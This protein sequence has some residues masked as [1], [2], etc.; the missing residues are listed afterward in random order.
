M[1]LR[2]GT[3]ASALARAQAGTVAADLHQHGHDVELVAMR[4]AGDRGAPAEDK[5]RWVTDLDQALLAGELDAAV[6]SAKDVPTALAEGLAIVC[7]PR[8]AD[9]RDAL[10]GVGDLESLSRGARVGTGSLRRAA[11]LLALR[12]D[13]ELVAVPG[14]VDTRLKRL[15]EGACDALVLALAGLVRLGREREAGG[16]IEPSAMLPAAGQGSLAIVVRVDDAA[17]CSAVVA[18]DDPASH[19]ALRAERA[20][21]RS[22]GAGCHTPVGALAQ[23]RDGDDLRLRLRGFAG[24]P[25][26]SAWVRDE[27]SGSADDP[28]ALGAAVA[29]RMLA[30]G[31][32]ELLREA[33]RMSSAG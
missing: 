4:V 17:V 18:L 33:E 25:D 21:V 5:S 13:L 31:A 23:H 7:V 12:A 8:R 32:G 14:N 2:V 10:C 27:L 29:A 24:L 6:H 28:E 11:Q 26:G 3:R 15:G 16:V 20:L 30:A 19:A 1:R 22:L 9:P